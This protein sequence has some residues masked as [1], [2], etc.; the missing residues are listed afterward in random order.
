MKIDVAPLAGARIEII[1]SFDLSS[2]VVVAPLAGARIEIFA[3]SFF[4]TP[5]M[6]RSPRG[7]AD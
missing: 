2:P 7:S 1:L 5:E 4:D 6:G 3:P